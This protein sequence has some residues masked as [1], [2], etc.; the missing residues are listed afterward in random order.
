MYTPA[1]IY[2][3]FYVCY[4]EITE[5]WL[6]Q[7]TRVVRVPEWHP[8]SASGQRAQRGAVRCGAVRGG[9]GAELSYL[10]NAMWPNT[11]PGARWS[12][13]GAVGPVAR[14]RHRRR[15]VNFK[16]RADHQ[17]AKGRTPPPTKAIAALGFRRIRTLDYRVN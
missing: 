7:E 15:A 11:D 17:G 13:K 2:N 3:V 8:Y 10:C 1:T 6:K 5:V 12:V 4:G 9:A 14:R 16:T